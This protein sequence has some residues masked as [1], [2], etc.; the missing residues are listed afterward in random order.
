MHKAVHMY[1][2]IYRLNF[3]S[4]RDCTKRK[5]RS[6]TECVQV[7]CISMACRVHTMQFC[8]LLFSKDEQLL[9]LQKGPKAHEYDPAVMFLSCVKL[10]IPVRCTPQKRAD[11]WLPIESV[12]SLAAS[13]RCIDLGLGNLY[14][15]P[16]SWRDTSLWF[17]L[18]LF[19]LSRPGEGQSRNNIAVSDSLPWG[20]LCICYNKE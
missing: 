9:C 16:G 11:T 12:A 8:S 14:S 18:P 4:Q 20:F 17:R 5:C 1:T 13:Y 15:L 19:P 7:V 6:L 3:S 2:Y 10:T